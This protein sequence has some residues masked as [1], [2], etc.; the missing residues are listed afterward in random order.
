LPWL[1]SFFEQA[2][3]ES[4]IFLDPADDVIR[5]IRFSNTGEARTIGITTEQAGLT[6]K[7]LNETLRQMGESIVLSAV[8][9]RP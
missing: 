7:D 4:T 1:K 2:V 3:D 5:H 6:A 9:F 8:Q